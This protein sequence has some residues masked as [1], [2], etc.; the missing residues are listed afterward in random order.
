MSLHGQILESRNSALELI[1]DPAETNALRLLITRRDLLSLIHDVFPN[2]A[3]QRL[4]NPDEMQEGYIYMDMPVQFI[5]NGP[6]IV[7]YQEDTVVG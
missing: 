6:P 4:V 2:E 5:D 7:V 1:V 3:A